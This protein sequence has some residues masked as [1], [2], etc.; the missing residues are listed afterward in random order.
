MDFTRFENFVFFL[1]KKN[2]FLHNYAITKINACKIKQNQILWCLF[3]TIIRRQ[4]KIVYKD[5]FKI[6]QILNYES[7][8]RRMKNEREKKRG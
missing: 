2:Y 8:K 1:E 6:K 7:N 5:K 3:E 4:A